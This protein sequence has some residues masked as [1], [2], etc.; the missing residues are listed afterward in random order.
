M[1]GI[2][3]ELKVSK[4]M[5]RNI[6]FLQE[7]ASINDVLDL[8]KKHHFHLF[9]VVNDE[10]NLVGI[11]DQDIILEIL[12]FHRIPRVKHTHLAAV[13]SLGS[14]VKGIMVTHPVTISP[15]TDLNE[16]ADLMLKH[17]VNNVCVVE[18]RKL[19]GVLTKHDII[20]EVIKRKRSV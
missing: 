17:R 3:P 20:N 1:S 6:V 8:F 10:G 14:D 5:E 2:F 11:I 9:P 7:D 18:N 16:A 12:L 19:V 4:L 13:R 15:D